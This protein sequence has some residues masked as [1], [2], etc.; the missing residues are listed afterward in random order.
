MSDKDVKWGRRRRRLEKDTRARFFALASLVLRHTRSLGSTSS[1]SKRRMAPDSSHGFEQ[2]ASS[3]LETT[4]SKFFLWKD[5]TPARLARLLLILNFW[6]PSAKHVTHSLCCSNYCLE[7]CLGVFSVAALASFFH[8]SPRL[9]QVALGLPRSLHSLHLDNSAQR[10]TLHPLQ[11]GLTSLHTAIPESS[12]PTT[13]SWRAS[14]V[15]SCTPVVSS[16]FLQGRSHARTLKIHTNT[17]VTILFVQA[18]SGF[19]RRVRHSHASNVH[20]YQ[21]RNHLKLH[22]TL[23]EKSDRN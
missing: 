5:D 12:I 2:H 11:R 8:V 13:T 22:G 9:Q 1:N 14:C 21:C 7:I 23:Q 19:Q 15:V 17:I 16:L 4:T 10:G 6:F 3:S 20:T 18:N